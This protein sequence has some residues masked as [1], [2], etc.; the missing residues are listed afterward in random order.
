MNLESIPVAIVVPAAA[1]AGAAAPP[2]AP[3]VPTTA[4]HLA[5]HERDAQRMFRLAFLP[6]RQQFVPLVAF[7]STAVGAFSLLWNPNYYILQPVFWS[8]HI[9]LMTP[10]FL[11]IWRK[12]AILYESV[13]IPIR[14]AYRGITLAFY[15]IF[16]IYWAYFSFLELYERIG[17]PWYKQIG[18]VFMSFVWYIFFAVSSAIYYYTATLLL[19]RGE[20]LK[21]H[22]YTITHATTK[23]IFFQTYDEEYEKNRRIGNTWNIIIF[24]VILVLTLNIPADLLGVLVNKKFIVIPGLIMKSLG[25]VWYL[26]CIC[27]LNYMETFVI[28]Y[29]HK[30]HLFQEDYDELMRYME[31]RRLGLNFFGVRITY[32]LLTKIGIIALNVILPTLYGLFSNH[33]L[34]I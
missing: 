3:A 14:P 28:N 13:G 6:P 10:A 8:S 29:L 4:L 26:L 23:D 25:L 15:A 21:A 31:V 20:T 33:I 22:I 27:K 18:H 12:R 17:D 9:M 34:Q 19:Q 16:M 1:T 32:E 5:S 30:H 7:L 2:A 24:L 11:Y